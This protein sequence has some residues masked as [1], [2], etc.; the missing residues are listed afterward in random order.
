MIWLINE[1]RMKEFSVLNQDVNLHVWGKGAIYLW[2][3][4]QCCSLR[5]LLGWLLLLLGHSWTS[6]FVLEVVVTSWG[7]DR[8]QGKAQ[9]ST[10]ALGMKCQSM[11]FLL[12]KCFFN[13]FFL[14]GRDPR[15]PGRVLSYL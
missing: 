9:E 3:S 13:F 4:I 2:F 1:S 6:S 5:A 8:S 11:C 14:V 15:G 10:L 12:L 7:A